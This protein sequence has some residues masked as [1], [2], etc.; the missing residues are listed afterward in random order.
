MGCAAFVR[1]DVTGL[2]L[3]SLRLARRSHRG[4]RPR[5]RCV[6]PLQRRRTE[7]AGSSSIVLGLIGDARD[8]EPPDERLMGGGYRKGT[9]LSLSWSRTSRRWVS[10]SILRANSGVRSLGWLRRRKEWEISTAPPLFV[11][12]LTKRR[13]LV[14]SSP[15]P[16][17]HESLSATATDNF[18][19]AC[20]GWSSARTGP[21][22]HARHLRLFV[23]FEFLRHL[24][25]MAGSSTRLAACVQPS[26]ELDGSFTKSFSRTDLGCGD[27]ASQE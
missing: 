11:L 10:M 22:S 26:F 7:G 12:P 25:S 21:S 4:S 2:V 17:C 9:H 6:L 3:G 19:H 8:A 16:P 15:S 13:A 27:Y 24:H 14:C 5:G 23:R 18:I 1:F 20:L